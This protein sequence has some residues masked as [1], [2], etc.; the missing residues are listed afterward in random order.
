MEQFDGAGLDQPFRGAVEQVQ[1]AGGQ[2]VFGCPRLFVIH[3]GVQECR[4]YAQFPQCCHLVLHQGDQ[5]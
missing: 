2:G 3:A 1:L 5:R 4:F